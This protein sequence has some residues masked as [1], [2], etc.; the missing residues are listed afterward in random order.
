MWKPNCFATD[1]YGHIFKQMKKFCKI[2]AWARQESCAAALKHPP[3]HPGLLFSSTPLL[4]C[5]V[6]C[7]SCASYTSHQCSHSWSFSCRSTPRCSQWAG[8]ARPSNTGFTQIILGS[9][10]E[11]VYTGSDSNWFLLCLQEGLSFNHLDLKDSGWLCK[12]C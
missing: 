3:E 4:Q 8:Y 7:G 11:N 10:A 1:I 5:S 12:K 9:L 2:W 6:C